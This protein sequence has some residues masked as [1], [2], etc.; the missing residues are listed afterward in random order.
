MIIR[1]KMNAKKPKKSD[2]F[3]YFFLVMEFCF[4][5]FSGCSGYHYSGL[6]SWK[7][8]NQYPRL[9]PYILELESE[10]GSL[11]YYGV[12]HSL[13]KGHNQF[14][15]IEEQW[16][17]FR[18]NVAFSEGGIWPLEKSRELSISRHGEQ[19][20]LRYL[21]KRDGV[22]LKSI[23]PKQ[24]Q[25]AIYLSRYFCVQKI[26]VFYIL[27]QAVIQRM[28]NKS[29]NEKHV[30]CILH[31]F[32]KPPFCNIGPISVAQFETY[33]AQLF[34]ELKDWRNIPEHWLYS[35]PPHDW[36]PKMFRMVNDFRN[37]FMIKKVLKE[38]KRG[39]RVFAVVGRSH[40]V[41]QEPVLRD[42][43]REF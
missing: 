9:N 4:C 32:E 39:K 16:M 11:I 27:R 35:L 8:Y 30:R 19:G 15:E 33:V 38:V 25:E 13:N 6:I 41:M 2:S 22:K 1:A 31:N 40:V 12:F 26:K 10:S 20:F 21:S 42:R 29:M 14:R 17:Q 3:L 34:P 43:I 28:L 23:E 36:L 24:I 7:E 37:Q 18:P 5:F